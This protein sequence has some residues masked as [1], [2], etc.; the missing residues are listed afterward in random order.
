MIRVEIEVQHLHG[1]VHIVETETGVPQSEE[2]ARA[3][4]ERAT[5]RAKTRATCA[6]MAREN[7]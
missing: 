7:T 5:K 4:I 3:L 1:K 6:V 2:Q